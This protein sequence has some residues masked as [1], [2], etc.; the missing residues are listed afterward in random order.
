MLIDSVPWRQNLKSWY[1]SYFFLIY[2][3]HSLSRLSTPLKG[4]ATYYLWITTLHML[5][6]LIVAQLVLYLFNW[7]ELWTNSAR[8]LDHPNCSV[9][10]FTNSLLTSEAGMISRGD[11]APTSCCFSSTPCSHHISSFP[12]IYAYSTWWFFVM[13]CIAS[14][15]IISALFFHPSFFSVSSPL[16]SFNQSPHFWRTHLLKSNQIS[17]PWSSPRNLLRLLS[18][19]LWFVLFCFLFF[20]SMYCT[21]TPSVILTLSQWKPSHLY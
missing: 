9:P 15:F 5:I 18:H 6:S 10:W 2:I 7:M 20:F 4:I 19:P 3:L 14:I 1:S 21:C 13:V 11:S 16:P 12:V 17:P 8:K